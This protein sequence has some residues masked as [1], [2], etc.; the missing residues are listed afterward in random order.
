MQG[1]RKF[2]IFTLVTII[3]PQQAHLRTCNIFMT[4]NFISCDLISSDAHCTFYYLM[5]IFYMSFLESGWGISLPILRQSPSSPVCFCIMAINHSAVITPSEILLTT[6][7][8]D[9]SFFL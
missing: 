6:D 1:P 5:L 2:Y 9:F 4:A 7:S 3:L 8:H